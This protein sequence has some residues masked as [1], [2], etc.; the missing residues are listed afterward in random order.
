MYPGN[1]DRNNGI[2]VIWGHHWRRKSATMTCDQLWHRWSDEI[3]VPDRGVHPEG[4]EHQEVPVD[5]RG[6]PLVT[7]TETTETGMMGC[8]ITPEGEIIPEVE[9]RGDPVLINDQGHAETN[10][11]EEPRHSQQV[12]V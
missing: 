10:V 6:S 4:I 2:S 9:M 11:N 7:E 1:G 12:R 3:S 8:R 5:Q